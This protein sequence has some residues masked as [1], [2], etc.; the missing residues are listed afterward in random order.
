M[1][2]A[3]RTLDAHLKKGLGS[4]YVIYGA[5][6]L[7]ALEASDRI[8]E[9]T[10]AAGYSEREVFTAEPGADWGKLAASA[11]NLSLF[12]SK[13]LYEI[14]IPTGKP[15]TEGS[16]ALVAYCARL[17]EDTITL[18]FLPELDWQ[19][20]KSTWFTALEA[21]GAMVEAKP[22]TREELPDWLATRLAKQKQHAAIETLEWLADRTEG[23]LLAARQ[24]VEKLGLLLPEGEITLEAIR[25]AVTDVSRFE[26]EALLDAVHAGDRAKVVRIVASL[27]AEGEP[28]PLL[29]WVLAEE[30]RHMMAL[31]ANQRPKRFLPPERM[32]ALNKT[33]RRHNP[34]SFAREL[35]RAH[36][37]DRMIK[38]VETGDPWDSMLELSLG[39]AGMPVLNEQAA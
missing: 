15:G 34:A 18:I 14:R 24:E 27:E 11:S 35:L 5:E 25:D 21:A 38:G 32:Q 12:A 29:L 33:A 13:R 19:Q 4:L 8:R 1:K 2:L 26:R 22:V 31:S 6:A 3:A 20:L 37:I 7:V 36:R 23:N 17:P 28:L 39:L 9:A 16:K 10:R 30:L